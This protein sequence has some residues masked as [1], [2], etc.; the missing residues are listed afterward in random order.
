MCRARIVQWYDRGMTKKK[1]PT[2]LLPVGRKRVI[3]ADITRKLE[4]AFSMDCTIEEACAYAGIS[5]DTY[6][7]ERKRDPVFAEKMDRAMQFPFVLAKKTVLQ[8]MKDNDGA[9]AMKWL[10]NRQR[11]RYHEKVTQ[12]T[13]EKPRDAAAELAEDMIARAKAKKNTPADAGT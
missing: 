1:K 2:E 6:S 9:L 10:K 13:T 12:E 5:D 8:A 7:R 11:D 3:D 4:E